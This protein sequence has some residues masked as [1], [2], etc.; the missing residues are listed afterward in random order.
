MKL[1]LLRPVPFLVLLLLS[2]LALACGDD[3]GSGDDTDAG[4]GGDTGG[5]G[6]AGDDGDSGGGVVL[7]PQDDTVSYSFVTHTRVAT[8]DEE[9]WQLWVAES[10]DADA[11]FDRGGIDPDRCELTE[12]T[13]GELTCRADCRMS[14]DLTR[15]FWID[16][17]NST[18]LMTAS[19]GND[20]T[21]A[22]EARILSQEVQVWQ[23]SDERV[24]YS[25]GSVLYSQPAAGG[26]EVQIVDLR[27]AQGRQTGGFQYIPHLDR[28]IVN[29]PTS[30]TAMDLWDMSAT[31]PSDRELLYHF[32]A[33]EEEGTGS[34][35]SNQIPI[36]VSPDGNLVAVFTETR[37]ATSG[38]SPTTDSCDAESTCSGATFRCI[39]ESLVLH[40]VDRRDANLLSV[41]GNVNRCS[42]TAEC[43]T[44]HLCDM[45]D[46]DAA[47]LGLCVPNKYVVGPYGRFSCENTRDGSP[48]LDAGEYHDVAAG[49]LWRSDG[50]IVFVGVRDCA[51]ADIAE[52]DVLAIDP[53]LG[54][55][56]VVIDSTGDDHGGPT[57]Q[58]P[59][60][61]TYD[62]D[63]CN[64][65]ITRAQLT[66]SG[67][68]LVMRAS[69]VSSR[70]NT[71]V[72]TADAFGRSDKLDGY[73][74]IRNEVLSIQAH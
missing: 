35:F 53:Q 58:D 45:S 48:F 69:T 23:A 16:P 46:T 73:R 43:G 51:G 74:D 42:Q 10:C 60:E 36:S 37:N 17:L 25:R 47:G 33:D 1:H 40:V 59:V 3:G 39:S 57:C 12:V 9:M 54:Q 32:V 41:P 6:D 22:D 44:N 5:G 56:E 27:A 14:P 11:E 29:L 13:G 21:V 61:G 30:L 15:V 4:G 18:T 50:S 72:W 26:T 67:T 70:T 24:V 62:P 68:T 66:P 31:D 52:T 65:E 55:L 8:G 64:V 7:P 34:F 71:T 28:I 20:F 2:T 19:V 49:P 63:G 38:C